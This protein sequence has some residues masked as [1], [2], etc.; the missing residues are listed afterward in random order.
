M[1]WSTRYAGTAGDNDSY[2]WYY[3]A[4]CEV[5]IG[6]ALPFRTA[7]MHE[8]KVWTARKTALHTSSG[9]AGHIWP[10]FISFVV[11]RFVV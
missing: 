5:I 8:P 3:W 10:L 7:V 9:A 4:R 6:L 1:S 2:D 11:L